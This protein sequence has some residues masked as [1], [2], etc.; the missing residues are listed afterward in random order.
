[1]RWQARIK[2]RTENTEV[3]IGLIWLRIGKSEE[4]L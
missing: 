1:M 4:L 2:Q 3:K